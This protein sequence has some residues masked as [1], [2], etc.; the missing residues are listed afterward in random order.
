MRVLHKEAEK[1]EQKCAEFMQRILFKIFNEQE[2]TYMYQ[3][4]LGFLKKKEP[5]VRIRL[6]THWNSPLGYVWVLF[7]GARKEHS[8]IIQKHCLNG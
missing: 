1:G 2:S 6:S 3:K 5:C 4:T 8:R 7:S